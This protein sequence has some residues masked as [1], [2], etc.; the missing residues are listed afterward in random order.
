MC[1]AS[2]W[3]L[4]SARLDH[5]PIEQKANALNLIASEYEIAQA[6]RDTRML[7]WLSAGFI[8]TLDR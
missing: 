4:T 7:I 8:A 6:N 5:L 3:W 2:A 1:L